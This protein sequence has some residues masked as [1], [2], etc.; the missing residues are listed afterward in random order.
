ME[1]KMLKFK[2]YIRL[3]SGEYAGMQIQKLKGRVDEALNIFGGLQQPG[4]PDS[5]QAAIE[6]EASYH[7]W[8]NELKDALIDII[9][10][11]GSSPKELQ[12]RLDNHPPI[13][14]ENGG[15]A[16]WCERCQSYWQCGC[17]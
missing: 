7:R 2:D 4:H 3:C 17:P 12:E 14:L 5:E 16:T 10:A 13:E 11:L 9:T 8:N 6:E 1:R 15:T